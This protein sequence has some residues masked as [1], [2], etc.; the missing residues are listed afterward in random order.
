MPVKGVVSSLVMPAAAPA[1]ES[2]RRVPCVRCERKEQSAAAAL[3]TV[4]QFH[5]L[6]IGAQEIAPLV[7]LPSLTELGELVVASRLLGFE[8]VPLEG[9]YDDLPEV[10]RPNIVLFNDGRFVVLYEIDAKQARV[11]DPLAGERTLSRD[12]FSS[13]WTGDCLQVVPARLDDARRRLAARRHLWTRLAQPR[14]LLFLA[15]ALAIAAPVA[16]DRTVASAALGVAALCSMWLVLF[17]AS[18]AQCNRAHQLAGALP[19]DRLG[20][21][22]YA[23]LLIAARFEP[24]LAG[25]ALCAAVG[26]HASLLALL[27]RERVVCRPCVV[28][29][30]AA[31]VAAAVLARGLP[32]AAVAFASVASAAALGLAVP[33]F[34]RVGRARALFESR[35]VALEWLASAGEP[36]PGKVRVV[37]WKRS[38][39]AACLSYEAVFKRALIEEFEDV[40]VIDERDASR[41]RI[42]TPLILVAGT[43][44]CLFVGLPG[45]DD[46]Y[47][48]LQRAVE[49]A[50]DPAFAALGRLG[51]VQL[52]EPS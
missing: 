5:E 18:C 4:A 24:R 15:G 19:L 7:G 49:S 2:A 38:G 30:V 27:A 29:G 35:R 45:R 8:S 3:A 25:Y 41:L 34:R 6:S 11:A 36:P 28:T 40:V 51:G 21:L 10:V 48:A 44:R 31:A 37:V 17:Q 52:I 33:F 26:G 23:S 1:T 14:P 32:L 42:P 39:C 22:F 47:E 50:R 13:Q 20:A 9:G 46:D 12:E 16:M 43:V